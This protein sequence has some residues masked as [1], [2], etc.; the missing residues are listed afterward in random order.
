MFSF[1]FFQWSIGWHSTCIKVV[2]ISRQVHHEDPCQSSSHKKVLHKQD[3]KSFAYRG[4]QSGLMSLSWPSS[5]LPAWALGCPLVF[6]RKTQ[7]TEKEVSRVPR[8]DCF[9]LEESHIQLVCCCDCDFTDSCSC[10]CFST[11]TN[12]NGSESCSEKHD[13][14]TTR[15]ANVDK[16]STSC[17]I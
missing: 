13:T 16:M 2:W 3:I 9:M 14:G 7:M 1:F 17:L 8:H 15:T 12:N 11:T 5:S 4:L 10:S 6:L